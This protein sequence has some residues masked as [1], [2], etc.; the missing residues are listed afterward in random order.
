MQKQK[1]DIYDKEVVKIPANSD[2]HNGTVE[3]DLRKESKEL[4]IFVPSET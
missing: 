2:A 4:L 1:Y 3:I